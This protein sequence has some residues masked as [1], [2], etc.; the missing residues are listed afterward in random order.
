[1]NN[2]TYYRTEDL[3]FILIL[4]YSE[5]ESSV[6][7]FVDPWKIGILDCFLFEGNLDDIRQEMNMP[8]LK[9]IEIDMTKAKYFI[10]MGDRICQRVGTPLT[11]VAKEW[12]IKLEIE[13]FETSGSIYKC[14]SCETGELDPKED[15]EIIRIAKRE[16]KRKVAG[17]IKEKQYYYICQEC[18][19]KLHK[20]HSD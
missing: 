2:F 5:N 7:Y 20:T 14:F 11:S 10:A 9:F 1:M 6:I 15:A 18:K 3:G 13:D 12:N 17:T 19:D 4:L 8:D 16:L